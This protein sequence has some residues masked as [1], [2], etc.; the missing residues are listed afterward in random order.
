MTSAGED[1][2]LLSSKRLSVFHHR[3][4]GDLRCGDSNPSLDDITSD[5]G[6]GG[7]P[8]DMT[9]E[10]PGPGR[11]SPRRAS[12]VLPEPPKVYLQSPFNDEC[13]YAVPNH[14]RRCSESVVGLSRIQLP[15]RLPIHA[16]Q[17]TDEE[18]LYSPQLPR[19]QFKSPWTAPVGESPTIYVPDGVVVLE[20]ECRFVT[21]FPFATLSRNH[22]SQSV[23]SLDPYGGYQPRDASTSPARPP[24][25]D[26]SMYSRHTSIP[27][28]SDVDEARKG[29]RALSPTSMGRLA[30]SMSKSW[31]ARKM[32][33]WPPRRSVVESLGTIDRAA[34]AKQISSKHLSQSIGDSLDRGS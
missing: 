5:A 31:N 34:S 9:L 33:F 2:H 17:E 16:I 32:K 13:Q 29:Y 21:P 1:H 7:L 19:R 22:R 20:D 28:H 12:E 11:S 23:V 10:C 14:T 15:S 25:K 4:T 26:T 6:F 30:R 27:N 18:S 8:T 3:S 24:S